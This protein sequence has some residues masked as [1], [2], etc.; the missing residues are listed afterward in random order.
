[1]GVGVGHLFNVQKIFGLKVD[2]RA[3]DWALFVQYAT[4]AD[5]GPHS[6]CHRFVLGNLAISANEGSLTAP[7]IVSMPHQ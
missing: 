7:L 3:L 4:V 2:S 6:E 1:M 5:I